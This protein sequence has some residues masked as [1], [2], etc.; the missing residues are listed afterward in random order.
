MLWR[1]FKLDWAYALGELVIVTAGVLIAL[2]VDQW[3]SDRLV[4]IEEASY[5]N[6]IITD[7][8]LD[9]E[10]LEYQRDIVVDKQESLARVAE[11]LRNGFSS[12]PMEFF[13]DIVDG[14]DFGWNQSAGV[15]TTYDDL[16]GSGNFA[17]IDDHD[18]RS[19]IT[20]Y[21]TGFEGRVRRLEER[22][23]E[24]PYLTY[25]LIPRAASVTRE[26]GIMERG[27][28]PD[29]SPEQ[30][31]IIYNN[32]R[33]SDLEALTVAESNFARFLLAITSY[34]LQQ[35]NTLRA[36]LEEYLATLE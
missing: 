13:D 25:K 1:K 30:V 21:Y 3:N 33:A 31:E 18:I 26:Y 29:L 22:E 32:I 12:E 15:R 2:A 24:Y 4:G 34:Q 23:T 7:I 8:D 16:V 36:T 11:Q 27:V 28:E 9:I 20:N 6:R 5:I 19:L 17:V 10:A 35:A 14:A